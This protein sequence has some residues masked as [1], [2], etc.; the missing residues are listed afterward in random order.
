MHIVAALV[1]DKSIV[2]HIN[3]ARAIA[4]KFFNLPQNESRK[5]L[6]D[7]YDNNIE[8]IEELLKSSNSKTFCDEDTYELISKAGVSKSV[9]DGEL[10]AG[11]FDNSRIADLL[12]ALGHLLGKEN[13]YYQ[14]I[15]NLVKG[16]KEGD[17][18][19]FWN[20]GEE[21]KNEIFPA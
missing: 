10:L 3:E 11:Y 8:K 7:K 12:A 5:T 6:L 20:V 19:V 1:T 4:S 17:L 14:N 13:S 9:E 18:L 16:M 21:K 15:D 2:N